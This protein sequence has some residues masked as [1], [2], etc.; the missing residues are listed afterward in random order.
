MIFRTAKKCCTIQFVSKII[1]LWFNP[2]TIFE[3]K[4]KIV[5][6]LLLFFDGFWWIQQVGIHQFHSTENNSNK[7]SSSFLKYFFG[8]QTIWINHNVNLTFPWKKLITPTKRSKILEVCIMWLRKRH[9]PFKIQVFYFQT[10][11]KVPFNRAFVFFEWR[12]SR[13]AK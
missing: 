1:P 7:S 6:F 11:F 9:A 12:A 4:N 2:L 13:Q 5:F 10:V 8:K 3:S